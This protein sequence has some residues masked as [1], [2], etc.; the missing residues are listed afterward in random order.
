MREVIFKHLST[1]ESRKKD[2]FLREVFEK[3][4]IVANTERRC[5]YFIKE[6]TKLADE[7]DLQKWLESQGGVEPVPK[8]HFC[9]L[10]EHNDELA[11]DRLICK[12]AGTF[13]AV[14][15]NCVYTIAFLH[16]FKVSF[17]KGS[18]TG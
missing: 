8:R 3:D 1:K 16:S 17:V 11:K 5:F 7:A 18:L 4:G 10:K 9:I 14:V 15:D 2:I 12:I 6:M 13:Y